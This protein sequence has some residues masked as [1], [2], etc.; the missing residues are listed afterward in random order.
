MSES[1]EESSSPLSDHNKEVERSED[2]SNDFSSIK[3]DNQDNSSSDLEDNA[4][5]EKK[6]NKITDSNRETGN[7]T[8]KDSDDES[9]DSFDFSKKNSKTNQLNSDSEEENEEAEIKNNL[10]TSNNDENE[11]NED[12]K[13][14]FD[15]EKLEEQNDNFISND[16]KEENKDDDRNDEN[17]VKN[18]EKTD[19]KEDFEDE[20]KLKKIKEADEILGNS[21][22]EE[23]FEGFGK[24]D[25]DSDSDNSETN[26]KKK[27]KRKTF[28]EDSDDEKNDEKVDSNVEANEEKE[29]EEKDGDKSVLPDISS[30]EDEDDDKRRSQGGDFVYD[31]DL[32][33]QKRKEQNSRSRKRKNIDLI[34][35]SDDFIADL[36]NQMKQAAEDD[37]ELNKDRKAATRKMKLLPIVQ[38][39]LRKIDLR[40]SFLESGVLGVMT[41]WLT[42]LP[43]RSLPNLQVRETMLKILLEFN[44][45]D[46]ERLKASGIGKAVM[47]LYKHPKEIKENKKRAGLLISNWSRPIFNCETD[48]QS[49]SKEDR[50]QRDYDNMSKLQKKQKTDESSGSGKNQSNLKP[51]DKG[52][53]PRARVPAPST[54]DYVV[55]PKSNIDMEMSRSGS[56]KAVSRLEKHLRNFQEKKR[57][58]KMQ[59]A[60]KISIEGRKL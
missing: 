31:F 36:L 35:D 18:D 20:S 9:E 46:V 45:M 27:N 16:G 58:S 41:D 30:S 17:Q 12:S 55:R 60:V 39:Q 13:L 26:L 7:K 44:I 24:R 10:D 29:S 57:T 54:K 48:Y 59:R 32:M 33:M 28:I 43:D 4:F 1:F 8:E 40:E 15:Y 3:N 37:F 6:N 11:K 21:D 47:Y 51:G 14:N 50:E 52:W 49:I 25:S 2:D 23:E 53:I 22:S 56:K 38:T 19:D 34:N 42:P 5:S